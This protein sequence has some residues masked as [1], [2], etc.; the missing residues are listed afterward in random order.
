MKNHTFLAA[1]AANCRLLT[2]PVAGLNPRVL[3][4]IVDAW[5]RMPWV[6]AW[7]DVDDP[8]GAFVARLPEE[9]DGGSIGEIVC[10]SFSMT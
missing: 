10:R 7:E 3:P 6:V 8:R 9:G 5:P 2:G 1:A 4:A